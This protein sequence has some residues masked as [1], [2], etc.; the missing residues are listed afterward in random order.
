MAEK[1][2]ITNPSMG[3][4]ALGTE[5]VEEVSTGISAGTN[6]Q[7]NLTVLGGKKRKGKPNTADDLRREKNKEEF[8][9]RNKID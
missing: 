4:N 1:E 8:L 6:T 7:L 5:T 9:A 2:I 3:S